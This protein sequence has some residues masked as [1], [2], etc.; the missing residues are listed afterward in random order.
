MKWLPL[1]TFLDK[2][3]RD[4]EVKINLIQGKMTENRYFVESNAGQVIDIHHGNLPEMLT[5]G[6]LYT[7]VSELEAREHSRTL[8]ARLGYENNITR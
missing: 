2:S 4:F 3:L 7:E 6:N 5:E 8:F 1:H